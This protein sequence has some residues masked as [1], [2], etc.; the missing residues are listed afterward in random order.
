MF[1]LLSYIDV[2][3]TPENACFSYDETTQIIC[4]NL[5]QRNSTFD[6]TVD[7]DFFYDG[8]I[9]ARNMI[10]YAIEYSGTGKGQGNKGDYLYYSYK[11]WGAQIDQN[12]NYD[13]V[14]TFNVT[15]YTNAEQEEWMN[16]KIQSTLQDLDLKNRQRASKK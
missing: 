2:S 7:Y 4:D 16:A 13:F 3:T 1:L 6:V 10:A 8:D 11:K 5:V 12:S 9:S 15:Y 14:F